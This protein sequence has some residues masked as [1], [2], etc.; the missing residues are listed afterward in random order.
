MFSTQYVVSYYIHA[1]ETSHQKITYDIIFWAGILTPPTSSTHFTWRPVLGRFSHTI[2]SD[3]GQIYS[4]Y[5]HNLRSWAGTLTLSMFS[6]YHPGQNFSDSGRTYS[7]C[8]CSPPSSRGGPA[9]PGSAPPPSG[10]PTR[11]CRK[12]AA[13]P[14]PAAAYYIILYYII[15]CYL[16][17][18]YIILY[19][20]ILYYS[21]RRYNTLW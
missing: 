7:R 15:I 11:R 3:S 10:R 8:R 13:P 2:L 16:I 6:H 9:R 14:A 19:C 1:Y 5:S 21:I 18:Y 12:D 17:L 20:I 4:H